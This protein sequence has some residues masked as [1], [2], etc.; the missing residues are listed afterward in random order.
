MRR[1]IVYTSNQLTPLRR[2]G[3]IQNIPWI[4]PFF[5]G[6]DRTDRDR[7]AQ[8]NGHIGEIECGPPSQMQQI[9]HAAAAETVKE[10]A[11]RA[12]ECGT[13]RDLRCRTLEQVAGVGTENHGGEQ[14]D[15]QQ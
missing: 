3:A 2:W 6:L 15:P 10:I 12:G 11:G 14:R 9:D 1:R 13:Q 5:I 8:G 4:A 7:H